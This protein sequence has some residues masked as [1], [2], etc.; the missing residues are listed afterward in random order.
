MADVSRLTKMKLW[1]K[2]KKRWILL[3]LLVAAVVV[4]IVVSNN[5]PADNGEDNTPVETTK[6]E[7]T[8]EATATTVSTDATEEPKEVY[9]QVVTMDGVEYV[10]WSEQEDWVRK[11]PEAPA[12][13]TPTEEP[14]EEYPKFVTID[15]V[16][17]VQWAEG[18]EYVRKYPEAPADITPEPET[19]ATEEPVQVYPLTVVVDGITYIIPEEGAEPVRIT[20]T[21][22]PTQEITVLPTIEPEVIQTVE[23]TKQPVIIQVVPHSEPPMVTATQTPTQ[24]PT[25]APTQ[26]PTEAPTQVPTE[27]P[28]QVPTEVP[29]Q[30]PTEAPT[31]VP[32]VVPV[33]PTEPPMAG[34]KLETVKAQVI[35]KASVAGEVLPTYDY[36]KTWDLYSYIDVSG[37]PADQLYGMLRP[38]FENVI[39]HSFQFDFSFVG[40]TSEDTLL[41]VLETAKADNGMLRLTWNGDNTAA[42]QRIFAGITNYDAA[43]QIMLNWLNDV[44]VANP[45]NTAERLFVC[46]H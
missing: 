18:E 31:E 29:T 7:T 38:W 19:V 10:K 39:A 11:Y 33:I 21:E 42:M 35:N 15:G 3:A 27:A 2:G 34:E 8:P 13:T 14:K 37:I 12:E 26:V 30:V 32:T 4:F 25:E 45:E 46:T 16:E 22:A 44:T 20:P 23:P 41:L 17:Y 28:T 9:P 5:K 43:N 40:N 6:V 36:G 24:A 1:L